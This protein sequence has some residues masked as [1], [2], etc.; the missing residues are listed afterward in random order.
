M[1]AITA[2]AVAPGLRFAL[3]LDFDNTITTSDVLDRVI[4]RYSVTERWRGWEADWRSGRISTRECL[5]KQVAELRVSADELIRFTDSID[6]DEA[7]EPLVTWA[8]EKG[9]ET[10]I[11]SDNFR[12]VI[13]AMLR[14][15]GLPLVPVFANSLSFAGDRPR[16]SFPFL[17]PAC[18]RCAHCKAQHLRRD[19]GRLRIFVG[20]GLSDICPASAADVTFAKDALAVHLR[21]SGCP[22]RPFRSLGDV[23]ESLAS[24][25]HA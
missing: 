18:E 24:L 15:R 20:D 3:F 7:F 25:V 13:E 23:L 12:I 8:T 6:I 1:S 5:E 10:A 16:A 9:I 17:D 19:A 11:V 22:F 21:S 2:D 4:E 14:R